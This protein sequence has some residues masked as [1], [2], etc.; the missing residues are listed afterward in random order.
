MGCLSLSVPETSKSMKHSG[1]EHCAS[2]VI[3]DS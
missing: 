3:D 2:S 1:C